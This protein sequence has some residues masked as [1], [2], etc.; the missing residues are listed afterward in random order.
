MEI[1]LDFLNRYAIALT[2]I[3]GLISALAS[4]IISLRALWRLRREER[5]REEAVDIKRRQVE[6]IIE[7]VQRVAPQ[8]DAFRVG[9]DER[10]AEYEKRYDK[11]V[12]ELV[13]TSNTSQVEKR[14]ARH[15]VLKSREVEI[16]SKIAAHESALRSFE[17]AIRRAKSGAPIPV[18]Q[19]ELS[20]NLERIMS[21]G[22][23][24]LG[25]GWL[26][27]IFSSATTFWMIWVH[28][29]DM[30]AREREQRENLISRLNENLDDIK[31]KI[32]GFRSDLVQIGQELV[33][34]DTKTEELPQSPSRKG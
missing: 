16:N 7:I 8:F 15:A 6:A 27:S 30:E 22:L 11:L 26:D 24:F 13:R 25:D 33:D 1:A 32:D 19:S 29:L 5:L 20:E 3:V 17:D 14:Q 10:L 23:L 21:S 12:E 31:V 2:S 4:L 28:Q 34:L 9:V 18:I